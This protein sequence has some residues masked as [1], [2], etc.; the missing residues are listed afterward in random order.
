MQLKDYMAHIRDCHA[1]LPGFAITC[2][3]YGCPQQ[4]KTWGSFRTHVYDRHGSDPSITN[5]QQRALSSSDH[6]HP[7]LQDD[8][9]N[10]TWWTAVDTSGTYLLFIIV[11]EYRKP[12]EINL[13]LVLN[14]TRGGGGGGGGG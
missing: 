1:Y 3:M 14:G 12:Q 8:Q 7:N 5:Q 11:Q 2:G 4:F 10:V 6:P 9:E 13:N